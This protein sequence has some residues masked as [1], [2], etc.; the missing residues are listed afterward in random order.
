MP[1][2]VSDRCTN[3]SRRGSLRRSSRHY[4]F[5]EMVPQDCGSE[6]SYNMNESSAFSFED[7]SQI[8]SLT[9]D[10]PLYQEKIQETWGHFVHE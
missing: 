2:L 3:I 6:C 5:N 7:P 1:G 8:R 10:Q 4:K 9:L